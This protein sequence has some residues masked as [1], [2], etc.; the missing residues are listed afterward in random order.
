MKTIVTFSLPPADA[1]D[2]AAQ[3]VVKRGTIAQLHGFAYDQPTDLLPALA[4][5]LQLL[6]DLEAT[7]PQIV[8]ETPAKPT[9]KAT[10]KPPQRRRALTEAPT[11]APNISA[12]PTV[13]LLE[14]IC[15]DQPRLF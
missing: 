9:A 15:T 11:E 14:P 4:H 10:A 5:A 13:T 3:V 8:A 7:P 12:P 1:T 2:R 6:A